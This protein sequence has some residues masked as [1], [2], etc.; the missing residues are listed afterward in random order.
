MF[1]RNDGTRNAVEHARKVAHLT[2]AGARVE[3]EAAV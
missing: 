2:G 1:T 3:A